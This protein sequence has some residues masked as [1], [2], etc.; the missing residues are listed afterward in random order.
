MKFLTKHALFLLEI[1]MN[2]KM[3]RKHIEVHN[4]TLSKFRSM[5]VRALINLIIEN[6]EELCIR[7]SFSFFFSF[8][9]FH[10]NQVPQIIIR[11]G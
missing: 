5:Q 2:C 3:I 8:F 1:K 6:G 10:E 4:S 9:V 7:V 11:L